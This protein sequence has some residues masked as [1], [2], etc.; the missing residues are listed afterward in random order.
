MLSGHLNPYGGNVVDKT[1]RSS[2]SA[3]NSR[4]DN[5]IANGT[6]TEG[7]T[8][9]IDIRTGADGTV[10][11]SAGEAVRRQIGD[12]SMLDRGEF[13]GTDLKTAR[14]FGYYR[15]Q[16]AV[17]SNITDLPIQSYAGRTLT[18]EVHTGFGGGIVQKIY[19]SNELA[20]GYYRYSPA[21]SSA[22]DWQNYTP[23]D[24]IYS[25][26]TKY[27]WCAIGDSFTH[28]DFTGVTAPIIKTGRYTG[29]LA[30]YPYLIGNRTN[31]AVANIAVNGMRIGG[32]NGFVA[33]QLSNI[34]TDSDYITIALGINDLPNHQNTPIGTINDTTYDTFY[35]AW[36]VLMNYLFNNFGDKHIGIIVTNGVGTQ[37]KAYSDA[38]IKIAEKWCVPYLNMS[39]GIQVPTMN[40]SSKSQSEHPS[41]VFTA[42]NNAFNVGGGNSHPNAKAH[43]YISVFVENWLQ[44]I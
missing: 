30:V 32:N 44:T 43:E 18:L 13:T 26:L 41:L 4:I 38:I 10:Y 21:V 17:S 23:G 33:T 20:R 3:V 22:N 7:N 12:K 1:A 16:G 36:N 24:S 11:A 25:P 8:E 2:I 27:K 15:I 29:Q 34:P 14:Q 28:G 6:P 31:M 39:Y 40:R 5:I 19:T 35:G 37:Y 9:L 42:R